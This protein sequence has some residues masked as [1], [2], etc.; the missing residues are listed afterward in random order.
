MRTKFDPPELNST[1]T[2]VAL[3]RHLSMPSPLELPGAAPLQRA[4]PQ[5]MAQGF[6]E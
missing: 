6:T 5:R 3:V 4:L 2:L 1:T